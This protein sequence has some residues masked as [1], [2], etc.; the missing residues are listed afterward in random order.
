MNSKDSETWE[1][2]TLGDLVTF[3]RGHDLPK[4]DMQQ[5]EYPVVGSNGI[6]GYHNE[7]KA[8]GPG[9]TIG[10]SGNLGEPFFA[11]SDFWPHNT[12]LYVKKFHQ[13]NPRFVYY[14][15][16][17]LR[18]ARF[19]AGSAVPTL[20][21]NHIHTI[22][23][24]VPRSVQEQ[25]AVAKILSDLDSK[26]EVNHQMNQTLEAIGQAIF[27]HWFVD[28]EFPNEEGK[29]YKSSGGE[30][31]DSELGKMPKGCKAGTLGELIEI[32]SG[33]RQG[34]RSD[35]KDDQFAVPLIGASKIMGYVQDFLFNEPIIV[36]G[37]VGTHGVIQRFS[38]PSFP[39]D[40]TLVLKS[41][42]YEYV[43]QALQRIDYASLN[44][45]STQPL[46]T[47]RSIKQ[48]ELIIPNRK[49]LLSFEQ[50]STS[51]F[52]KI[53]SN[54]IESGILSQIRDSLLPKLMSGKIRVP[55]EVQ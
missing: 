11:D 45:G 22:P 46:I 36:T 47:Q 53:S 41:E 32:T 18:L 42:F 34:K 54:N 3:Q 55:L 29:P 15:L 7:C 44:V 43:Y 23:I 26:I 52:G 17:T 50:I 28:F 1:E 8:E 12:T 21:R 27:K 38:G 20:N 25:K 6:I 49:T 9:V 30:M 35:G 19:N 37:R 51:L 14:F 10:R 2:V 31:V 33:K 4:K 48:H 24:S 40:N 39:S 13:C 5:G 16:K